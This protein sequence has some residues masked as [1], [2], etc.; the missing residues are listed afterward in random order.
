MEQKQSSKFMVDD[1]QDM[2]IR[3][4]IKITNIF[5]L[6]VIQPLKIYKTMSESVTRDCIMT[7]DL[8]TFVTG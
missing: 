3:C 7:M 2:Y 1:D 4:Y 6:R 5:D 8:H